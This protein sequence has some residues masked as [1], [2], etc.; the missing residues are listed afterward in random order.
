MKAKAKLYGP[1]LLAALLCALVFATG[2]MKKPSEFELLN[3]QYMQL[4][5]GK[6]RYAV[7]DGDAYGALPGEMAGLHLPAG[8]YRLRWM[9]SGDGDNVLRL[10]NDDGAAIT[11]DEFVLPADEGEGEC[12]FEIEEACENFAVEIEF[13]SGSYLDVY[14]LKLYTPKYQDDAFTLLFFAIGASVLYGLLATGRLTRRNMAPALFIGLAVL[15]SCSMSLKSTFN[16]GHDG[17]YHLARLQNLADGL[18]SGQFPVRMGG[19]SF[20]GYGAITSVFYPDVFLYPFALMLLGGA[21]AAYVGNVLLA[22]LNIGAA[23]GMYAAAKRLFQN[24]WA[25][26]C[27]SVLYTLS[28]YRVMDVYTRVAVGEAMAMAFFPLFIVGLYEALFG[29]AKCW[30]MLALSACGIFLSHM[31]STMLCAVLAAG[32][33]LLCLRRVIGQKRFVP[34]AKAAG[35]C[36]LLGLFQLAPFCMYSMQG[37]GAGTL[38]NDLTVNAVEPGQI[39]MMGAGSASGSSANQ[40]VLAFSVEIGLPLLIGA[41]LALYAALQKPERGENEKAVLRLLACGA[42]LAVAA[43]DFFPWG[44][45]S[46]L[47]GGKVGYMQFTWRLL[48]FVAPLLALAGGYGVT[49]LGGKRPD[50]AAAA[51]LCMAAVCVMPTLSGELHGARYI[52]QG[53][54]VSPHLGLAYAEYTLPDTNFL[55]TRDRSLHIEGGVAVADYAKRGTTIT[56]QVE[57]A[58]EGTVSFPLF[59]YDGYRATL[60]GQEIAVET[61][62]NNRVQIRVPAGTDGEVRIWFAGKRWWKITDAV[63]LAALLAVLLRRKFGKQA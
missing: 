1:M 3:G 62:D 21:S 24:R 16:Y 34:L 29:D 25:A 39:L 36:L 12:V 19:F 4:A 41:M 31:L 48:M 50:A 60:N 38:V 56:A 59:D 45:V 15:L 30:R 6:T 63:S 26:T 7:A 46:T 22:A 33:A 53:A 58:T 20:N 18:K 17:A 10:K 23:A 47:T 42:A 11:P 13:A 32:A 49:E 5:G 54:T 61:G 55:E 14:G 28:A 37:I 51:A 8:K 9:I 57:A 52:E 44:P 40:K 43:T 35:L 27:A 2:A